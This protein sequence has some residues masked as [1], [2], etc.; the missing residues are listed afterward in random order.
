MRISDWSSDVCSSELRH[1]T[2]TRDGT[3]K[4][5]HVD[6]WRPIHA[7]TE[8]QVWAVIQRFG[9]VP[10]VA[11]QLGWGRLS[12]RSCIFGSPDQWATIEVVFPEHLERIAA[13]EDEA[14]CTIQRKQCA[15]EMGEKGEGRG[16]GR[17]GG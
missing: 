9:I 13:R 1:R 11:Y 17:G 2:D 3:R 6:H 14:G 16:G 12:C 15:R 10:H 5:R 7:W 4:A 8:E